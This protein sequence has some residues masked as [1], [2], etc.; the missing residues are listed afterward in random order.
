MQIGET[1]K[2]ENLEFVL[3]AL[4]DVIPCSF[5]SH[6]CDR[7]HRK[8]ADVIYKLSRNEQ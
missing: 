8:I 1:G 2:E 5:K 4:D 3:P 6:L 7:C